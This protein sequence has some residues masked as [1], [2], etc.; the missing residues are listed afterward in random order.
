MTRGPGSGSKIPLKKTAP[1][2]QASNSRE[3]PNLIRYGAFVPDITDK[4]DI[5][6]ITAQ[7]TRQL[8]SFKPGPYH[9]RLLGKH[10][11]SNLQDKPEKYWVFRV[12]NTTAKV[13]EERGRVFQF[14]LSKVTLRRDS[15]HH[16]QSV[17]KKPEAD[18]VEELLREILEIKSQGG[19]E[20][21]TEAE[22]ATAEKDK[23]TST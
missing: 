12:M 10:K 11:T 9:I 21:E 6:L 3:G 19:S 7:M 16:L 8:T 4:I 14:P 2:Y 18:K 1:G 23:G 17:E 15:H 20:M 22:A 13:I 5:N